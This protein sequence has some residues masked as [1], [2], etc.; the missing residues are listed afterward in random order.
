MTCYKIIFAETPAVNMVK[1]EDFFFQDFNQHTAITG[2]WIDGKDYEI[3]IQIKSIKL[4]MRLFFTYTK[5]L[6]DVKITPNGNSTIKQ[7]KVFS[8][9]TFAFYFLAK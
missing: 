7:G 8:I 5:G 2:S 1:K 4:E 9:A 3:E 6:T